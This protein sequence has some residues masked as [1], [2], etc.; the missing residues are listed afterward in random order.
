MTR[1]SRAAGWP[2][3][4]PSLLGLC[5][6][7][8]LIGLALALPHGVNRAIQQWESELNDHVVIALPSAEGRHAE[9]IS[10]LP[11]TLM[12]AFPGT[13]ATRLPD[14]DVEHSLAT[15][16][17]PWEGPLPTLIT[18]HY[19]GD[20]TALTSF[21]HQHA[22]EA[23]VIPPPP[24]LTKLTPLMA[25]LRHAA[26]SIA[27]AAG[28]G[29]ALIVPAL[30]YLGARTIALANASQL[31]LLPTLG[32]KTSSL[33]HVLAL[34]MALMIFPGSLAGIGLLVPALALITS[35]LR[36]LLRLPPFA[37]FASALHAQAFL[38]LS[39]W[40]T[41]FLLPFLMALAGWGMVHLVLFRQEH[42]S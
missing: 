25:D 34:R 15:W 24:Q 13:Q 5:L 20:M 37:G 16:S 30:L 1:L 36:P 8:W 41:L 42:R 27:L 2:S 23:T 40:G 14:R 7:T 38:P 21:V 35:A 10:T 9:Q 26:G 17:T 29:A 39:L 31:A 11:Q 6:I 22:P 33:H 28:L 4:W 19:H 3:P 12:T 32:G 18:L